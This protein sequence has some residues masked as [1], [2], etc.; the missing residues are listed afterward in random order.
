[1]AEAFDAG[2]A[3][4]CTQNIYHFTETSIRS[5]K[6]YLAKRGLPVRV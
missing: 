1:M 3:A 2:A 6:A 4:A 5:A